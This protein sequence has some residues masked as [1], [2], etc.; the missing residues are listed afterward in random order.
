MMDSSSSSGCRGLVGACFASS[1]PAVAEGDKASASAAE[2]ESVIG[3]ET[4]VQLNTRTK[5]FCSCK[6]E[7]GGKPNANVCPVCLGHP[8][9]LPSLNKKMVELA[10]KMGVALNC[11]IHGESK[12]DRKQY[13]YGDLPKGYQISQN[14][15]P[16]ATEG[17]VEAPMF[18]V[19]MQTDAFPTCKVRI[20]RLHMEEDTAK[21]TH[22]GQDSLATSNDGGGD[23]DGAS[24]GSA[25]TLADYNRAGVPLIEI[26]T[27]PDMRSGE[28]AAA[29]AQ[30]LRRIVRYL[31]VSS[32]NMQEGSLRC[33]VN[34]SVRRKGET[35][36]GTKVEVKNLNSFSAV[37]SA[38]EYETRRQSTLIEEG[39]GGEIVQET[40]LWD[41][42]RAETKS[43]RSKEEAADYRYLREPDLPFLVLKDGQVSEIE[44]SMPEL[45]G[46]VRQKLL[47]MGLT[48]A[49]AAIVSDDVNLWHYFSK[50][51]DLG[52]D[53]K[54][55]CNWL[56]GDILAFLNGKKLSIEEAKMSPQSLHE[57]IALIEEGVIS[58][59]I[60]KQILPEVLDS[61][62]SPK[63]VVEAKGLVQISDEGELGEII[64][65]IISKNP[66]QVEQYRGGKTK[67]FGFF[68]GQTMKATQGKANPK[69][70][71]DIVKSKLDA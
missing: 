47:A 27:E 54:A 53:P 29:Y 58:G 55:A 41:E 45:P 15:R 39:R 63:E 16:I 33:D 61:G 20:H 71:N 38:V 8:G 13:F 57:M 18:V 9:M 1:A 6:S 5:A 4:H 70:V 26:V 56:V 23:D 40:R 65:E 25:S 3:V 31:G 43:M 2:W 60:A 64:G 69:L 59:K 21:L 52:T 68:V 42:A 22:E 67:L 30:E 51:V 36:L 46:Q 32:G 49:D 12:F 7:Y 19:G 37:K 14:D 35:R 48:V 10:I 62:K 34:I 44:G 11:S 66:K 28:E 50:V 17:L 24:S